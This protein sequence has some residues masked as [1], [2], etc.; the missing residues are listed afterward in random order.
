[1]ALAFD[2][3]L[4]KILT[5]TNGCALLS[6]SVGYIMFDTSKMRAIDFDFAL[7]AQRS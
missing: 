2:L 5:G 6:I 4:M 7:V 1:V 3:A